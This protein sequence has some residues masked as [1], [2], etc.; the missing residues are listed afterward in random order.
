[1]VHEHMACS[2]QCAMT[3][4]APVQVLLDGGE[5]KCLR[6]SAQAGSLAHIMRPAASTYVICMLTLQSTSIHSTT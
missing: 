6:D 2:R 1:M 4:C 5:P 3:M